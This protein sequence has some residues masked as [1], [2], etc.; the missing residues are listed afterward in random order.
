MND[1][2]KGPLLAIDTSTATGSVAIGNG[3]RLLVEI[4][5]GITGRHSTALMP[6]VDAALRWAGATPRQL[7]GVVVSGGP[8]SFTGLRIGAATAKGIVHALRLPLWSFSGL[9]V[10]AASVAAP[11]P[12]APQTICALFD[13]R[14]RTVFSGVYRFRT[15]G[16]ETSVDSISGP[17]VTEIDLLMERLRGSETPLFT[18]DGAHAHR[19]EIVRG[20]GAAIAPSHLALPRA[21]SLLWLCSLAPGLGLVEDPVAWEPEYLRPSGAERIAAQRQAGEP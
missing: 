3:D 21:S 10:A 18:G 6:A 8:G 16:H 4:V 19:E 20:L 1:A 2:S 12:G 15:S 14:R 7:R 5:L 9:L 13:A 11:G 17:E